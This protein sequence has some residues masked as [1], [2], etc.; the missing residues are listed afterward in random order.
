M[1]YPGEDVI[2]EGNYQQYLAPYVGSDQLPRAKGLTPRNYHT[3]PMGCYGSILPYTAVD[4]KPFDRSTWAERIQ[5]QIADKGRCSDIRAR[6]KNKQPIPS[7]DQN[8]KGYC[9]QHSGT[10]ATLIIRAKANLKFADLSAYAGACVQKNFRDEGGWGAQGVDFI[11]SRGLPTSEFWPQRSMSRANDNPRTWENAALHKLTEG[12]IDLA[13]AQYDRNLS[14]EQVVT[15]L[16]AGFPVVVDFNWWSHSVCACDV[17][18]GS[19][20]RLKTR[21]ASGKKA[22]VAEFEM[23]WGMRD[24]VTAG[25]GIRIWNS[26]GDSW[27]SQ[28][29]GVLTGNQAI[30]DGSVCPRAVLASAA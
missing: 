11:I 14:F 30:P 19:G 6:G 8:G 26:W 13:A 25:Y 5:A 22:S 24:E 2:H 3:H 20:M 29:M 23:I 17:V 4:L 15:C 10:S 7:T 18:N 16:L 1:M 21:S 12:W 9:W 28:G 27:S